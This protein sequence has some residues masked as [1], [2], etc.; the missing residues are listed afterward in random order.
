MSYKNNCTI[1]WKFESGS[2]EVCILPNAYT[3]IQT[4]SSGTIVEELDIL[5]LAHQGTQH[6][7]LMSNQLKYVSKSAFTPKNLKAGKILNA[8]NKKN[9][10]K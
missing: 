4:P 5:E 8:Q 7:H 10:Q 2:P 1:F 9:K 3:G 6:F